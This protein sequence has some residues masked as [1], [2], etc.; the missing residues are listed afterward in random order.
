[1]LADLSEKLDEV[2]NAERRIM[3]E[4]DEEARLEEMEAKR[5]E[6]EQARLLAGEGE[7]YVA[8]FTVVSYAVDEETQ[9][10]VLTLD[11][12]TTDC[13]LPAEMVGE[14]QAKLAEEPADGEEKKPVLLSVNKSTKTVLGFA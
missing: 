5:I 10:G 2:E 8:T 6:A 9:V 14:L 3:A 11:D 12:E 13:A 4:K 1:V 7:E